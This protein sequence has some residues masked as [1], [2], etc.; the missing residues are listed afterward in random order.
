MRTVW[1]QHQTTG[2]SGYQKSI[3]AII[4]S[5]LPDAICVSIRYRTFCGQPGNIVIPPQCAAE[6]RISKPEQIPPR[7]IKE[8]RAC[9]S[10][11]RKAAHRTR[12]YCTPKQ[13]AVP[14]SLPSA[15]RP[16]ELR[17]TIRGA[18]RWVAGRAGMRSRAD[19]PP[20]GSGRKGWASCRAIWQGQRVDPAIASLYDALFADARL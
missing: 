15:V 12:Y 19:P 17:A 16:G 20:S 10:K 5:N 11:A 4:I 13:G 7:A 6:R 9:L 3:V 14:I 8:A 18:L 1:W 2:A